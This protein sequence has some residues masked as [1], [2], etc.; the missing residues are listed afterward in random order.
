MELGLLLIVLNI[1]IDKSLNKKADAARKKVG[2]GGGGS[3]PFAPPRPPR[4]RVPSDYYPKV[5][6]TLIARILPPLVLLGI[7]TLVGHFRGGLP[8]FFEYLRMLLKISAV[9]YAII[10][11]AEGCVKHGTPHPRFWKNIMMQGYLLSAPVAFYLSLKFFHALPLKIWAIIIFVIYG[12]IY[13]LT[14]IGTLV[15]KD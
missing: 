11:L 1:N 4:R 12:I 8:T 2:L 3:R 13:V 7:L 10:G 15:S 14:T 9:F 6:G 5:I